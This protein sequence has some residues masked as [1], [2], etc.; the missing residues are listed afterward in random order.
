[1][2]ALYLIA[3]VLMASSVDQ[4]F[5][6]GVNYGGVDMSFNQMMQQQEM[7]NR[8]NQMEQDMYMQQ[9]QQQHE[10]YRLQQEMEKNN[11]MNQ[12]APYSPIWQ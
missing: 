9:Q 4:A 5:A 7:E 2:K 1:M 12:Y 6:T 11:R 8:M 3:L 10:N